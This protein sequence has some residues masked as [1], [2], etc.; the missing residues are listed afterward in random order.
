MVTSK[1]FLV[2]HKGAVAEAG[3]YRGT[4]REKLI[5]VF[6]IENYFFLIHFKVLLSQIYF[7]E[8]KNSHVVADYLKE[9]SEELVLRKMPIKENCVIKKGF[10]QETAK[11]IN[12][13]FVYVSLLVG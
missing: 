9:T 5:D 7:E 11:N 3:V 12:E 13:I 1:L 2:K 8:R 10:F 6:Q 4:I